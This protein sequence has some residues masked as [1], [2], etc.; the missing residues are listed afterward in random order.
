MWV[1]RANTRPAVVVEVNCNQLISCMHIWLAVLWMQNTVDFLVFRKILQERAIQFTQYTRLTLWHG[2]L[3]DFLPC[4]TWVMQWEQNMIV[5]CYLASSKLVYA[6]VKSE[7]L[8]RWSC[9]DLE[10][11]NNTLFSRYFFNSCHKL[12]CHELCSFF[13]LIDTATTFACAHFQR[14]SACYTTHDCVMNSL[15]IQYI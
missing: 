7:G 12:S 5:I 14:M 2:T 9:V 11:L 13:T 15:C 8:T 1:V 10:D 4:G 6:W 3:C